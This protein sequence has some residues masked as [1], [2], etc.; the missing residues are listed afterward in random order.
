MSVIT[1]IGTFAACTSPLDQEAEST[2]VSLQEL[3][4]FGSPTASGTKTKVSRELEVDASPI[5]GGAPSSDPVVALGGAQHLVVWSDQRAGRGLLFGAR[6][7]LDGTLRDPHGIRIFDDPSMP[8]DHVTAARPNVASDGEDFL[9]VFDVNGEIRGVR[10]NHLGVVL[11]PGGILLSSGAGNGFPT[12]SF[13]GGSYLV[14]WTRQDAGALNDD[15]YRARVA[16]DGTVLD[17]GGALLGVPDGRYPDLAFDGT[18]HFM[19]W[20]AGTPDGGCQIF[21]ARISPL[22]AT[23]DPSGIPIGSTVGGCLSWTRRPRVSFDGTNL[24]VLWIPDLVFLPDDPWFI[25]YEQLRATRVTP[26]G[27][28]LDPEGIVVVTLVDGFSAYFSGFDGASDG[29]GTTIAW[30]PSEA[31]YWTFVRIAQLDPDGTVTHPVSDGLDQGGNV[32]VASR[33]DGA[34]VTWTAG[35]EFSALAPI[36]AMR[37]DA[38]GDAEDPQRVLISTT[39]NVQEVEAAASSGQGSLVIWSDTRLGIYS[40]RLVG[41]LVAPSGEVDA[42]GIM[43]PAT[44]DTQGASAV[45]DGINFRVLWRPWPYDSPNGRPIRSVRV[46]PQGAVLDAVPVSLPVCSAGYGALAAASDGTN[47]LLVG[48]D[49]SESYQGA[50]A[51]VDPQDATVSIVPLGIPDDVFSG[52]RVTFGGTSY[53]VTWHDDDVV[54]GQRVSP[55]GAL[56]DAAPFVIGSG[57]QVSSLTVGV[58]GGKHLVVWHT[59]SGLFGARVNFSGQV[60]DPQGFLVAT[61][62]LINGSCAPYNSGEACSSVAFDGRYFVVAWRAE[63]TPG[64]PN[65]RDVF[66]TKVSPSG[67]VLPS[68]AIS[69]AKETEGPPILTSNGHGKVLAAYSRFVPEAPYSARRAR[70]RVLSPAA[71]RRSFRSG[72][73]GGP[74][75]PANR[76]AGCPGP[77]R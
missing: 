40:P 75:S 49:C 6:V 21:G 50:A 39:A 7:E 27:V 8:S 28:V 67:P 71:T 4:S 38:N 2:A 48:N 11:D 36:A 46:S 20:F 10:V 72:A 18:N 1:L 58:G 77:R 33:G 76:G 51:L 44:W 15:L 35:E 37:L 29:T 9:V 23:L 57:A 42:S 43:I 34:F 60:L 56:L 59:A 73:R 24:V 5:F 66:A 53:L 69:E 41:A 25:P 54:Y 22:G 45:F 14:A 52:V 17:P 19:T 47:T 31:N 55:Q 68:F 63:A 30:G 13:D 74:R 62:S 70:M 61:P 64:D 26:Q 16:P 65:T 3:A 12:V 32:A